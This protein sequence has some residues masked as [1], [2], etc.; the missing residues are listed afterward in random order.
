MTVVGLLW[1]LDELLTIKDTHKYG[2]ISEQNP[3]MRYFLRK[4]RT[5]LIGFKI[6][7]FL[8]FAFLTTAVYYINTTLAYIITIFVISV[9]ILVDV[10]NYRILFNNDNED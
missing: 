10:N 1:F 5:Q 2:L 8:I 6:I 9:Y 4:G 3:V 7:S